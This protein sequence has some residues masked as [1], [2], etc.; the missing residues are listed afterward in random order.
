MN[1]SHNAHCETFL[2]LF[3]LPAA[4]SVCFGFL[5]SFHNNSA[6]KH[7]SPFFLPLSRKLKDEQGNYKFGEL[8]PVYF[9][10][11]C[12]SAN[13]LWSENIN[14]IR[15]SHLCRN[16]P[17]HQSSK[18]VICEE[19]GLCLPNQPKIS[20]HYFLREWWCTGKTRISPEPLYSQES[21]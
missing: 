6:G 5:P 13:W 20:L 3:I 11:L 4:N 2:H 10:C 1:V 17:V 9:L 15:A 14:K 19:K 12:C 7:F 21:N 8:M 18:F 16:E